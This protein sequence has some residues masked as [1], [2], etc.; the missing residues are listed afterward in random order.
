M[1]HS[2]RR[3]WPEYLIEAA[4]LGAFMISACLFTALFE[5]PDSPIRHAIQ[6]GMLRRVLIGIAMGLTAIAI[7]YSRWGKRSGAHINPATTFTFWRLGKIET[8]D[9]VGYATAQFGG[10]VVGVLVSAWLL[11]ARVADPS[12]NYVTTVPGAG[13]PVVFL[14]ELSMAFGMML[15]VLI[16]S[17]HRGLAPYTGLFAGLLVAIYISLEAPIS[18][19]SINPARTFGSALPSWIWSGFWI[20]LF[21]P[22]AGMLLAAEVY[23]KARARAE[24]HCAKLH[25]TNNERCIFRCNFGALLSAESAAASS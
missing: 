12:V 20:Y 19:M 6:N 14:A 9:A 18:G 11:G 10:A 2:L 23:S 5:L 15:M 17:N 16:C 22:P 4:G 21:A 24:I 1:F 25:H 3:H 8:P 7:I 13:W